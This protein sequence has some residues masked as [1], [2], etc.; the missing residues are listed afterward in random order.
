MG[1]ERSRAAPCLPRHRDPPDRQRPRARRHRPAHVG[2]AVHPC[3]RVGHQRRRRAQRSRVHLRPRDRARHG[4]RER[5]AHPDRG[6][7]RGRA[8]VSRAPTRTR[9]RAELVRR[10]VAA[11]VRPAAQLAPRLVRARA[12]AHALGA[13]GE[14][15]GRAGRVAPRRGQ[16]AR[17]GVRIRARPRVAVRA[18]VRSG[19]RPVSRCRQRP[20]RREQRGERRC[21]GPLPD[22]PA[23]APHPWPQ[24][25][26]RPAARVGSPRHRGAGRRRR[27][28]GLGLPGSSTAVARQSDRADPFIPRLARAL[29][30]TGRGAPRDRRLTRRAEPKHAAGDAAGPCRAHARAVAQG[31]RA[32]QVSGGSVEEARMRPTAD[33]PDDPRLP[34]LMAI[35]D[36][37]LARA[38]PALGLEQGAGGVEL[39]LCGY[40]PGARATL[41]ARVGQRRFA[42]KTFA[43]DPTPEAALY[44][45]LGAAGLAG[46]SGARVPPLLARDYHLRWPGFGCCTP[47]TPARRCGRS[48]RFW[49]G[50]A[51]CWTSA[52]WH[53]IERPRCCSSLSV[54]RPPG[55][56]IGGS[57]RTRC[58]ARPLGWPSARR[59]GSGLP[60][61]SWCCKHS[62]R[63]R[64][65]GKSSTRSARCS[66]K[67]TTELPDDPAL[68]ALA[69]I[70]ALGLAA[71]IPGLGLDDRPVELTLRGY[72]P[73]SRA[74]LEVRAGDR[75]FALKLYAEDPA[76]EAELYEA[77]AAV[78][79]VGAGPVRVPPLLARDRTLQV[80]AI[81]WLEGP[82]A[83]ELLKGRRGE[84]AGELAACWL[85]CAA[86]LPVN[87]G[88]PLGAAHMVYNAGK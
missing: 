5:D 81:G 23:G 21:Y 47:R 84:R 60:R 19:D 46:D 42:V 50:R 52:R 25:P 9:R 66:V 6:R 49:R 62:R 48:R 2:C 83:Q 59:S 63:G 57:G 1:D 16:P 29:R 64:P 8:A 37:G 27:R 17:V 72:T 14:P 28:A 35:R 87:V 65:H 44:Q 58:W 40:H 56:A 54:C 15:D 45:A 3:G 76:P 11:V 10:S 71:A 75:H 12:P 4:G 7:P 51:T 61:S 38:I 24:P 33:L 88:L 67:A 53:G 31:P 26:A 55:V 36:S 18:W 43:D 74:T 20:F 77:L 85:R 78:G 80:L 70:R 13:H 30:G 69:A 22:R 39:V 86:A 73:G 82:T 68:P 34:G 32:A 41:D 79:L